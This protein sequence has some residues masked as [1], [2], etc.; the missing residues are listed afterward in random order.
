MNVLRNLLSV[1][2]IALFINC[3]T[4]SIERSAQFINFTHAIYKPFLNNIVGRLRDN[5]CAI[6]EF[7]ECVALFIN[8]ANL[9]TAPD[10]DM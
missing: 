10:I 4:H 9:Q 2:Y 5:F 8:C 3:T 6:Y 7:I 1:D